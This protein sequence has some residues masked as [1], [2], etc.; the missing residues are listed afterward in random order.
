MGEGGNMM[1]ET[2]IG[3]RL[4]LYI[5]FYAICLTLEPS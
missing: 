2:R 5:L 3:T 1:D 4:L